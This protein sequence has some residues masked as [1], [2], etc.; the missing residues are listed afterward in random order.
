MWPLKGEQEC[1]YSQSLVMFTTNTVS[2]EC[3]SYA[4]YFAMCYK[5]IYQ[6][7]HFLKILLYG[8]LFLPNP[9]SIWRDMCQARANPDYFCLRSLTILNKIF[10]NTDFSS[11]KPMQRCKNI[12]ILNDPSHKI[13]LFANSRGKHNLADISVLFPC[14]WQVT[15][16]QS[17]S[18]M[19][20]SG[21]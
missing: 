8:Y 6:N 15:P 17:S 1:M 11:L 2:T 7:M 10:S 3:F 16:F 19:K 20:L 9:V 5:D 21:I 13:S 18:C 12:H 14:L 4:R